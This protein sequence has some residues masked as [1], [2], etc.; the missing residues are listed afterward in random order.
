MKNVRAITLSI[1]ITAVFIFPSPVSASCIEIRTPEEGLEIS[2][3][4]FTGGVVY[5]SSANGILNNGITQI[6]MSLRGDLAD[7]QGNI[8]KGRKIVFEVDRAWKGVTTSSVTIWTGYSTGNSSGYPFELGDYYLVY[9][10]HAYGDPDKYLLTSLC[11]RTLAHP[12]NSED[13][14]YLNT[15]PT[16]E[17]SYFPAIV[18][19]IDTS[20][21]IIM[22]LLVSLMYAIRRK[23]ALR[24]TS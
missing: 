17:I 19:T 8:I 3:A 1:L 2:D 6:L 22:L 24:I 12:N 20:F 5:I 23:S 7:I 11:S 15:L 18:R 16:L 10:N 21:M 4:V 9:A 14:S 13:I